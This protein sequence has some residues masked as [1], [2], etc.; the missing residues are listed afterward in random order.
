VVPS[1]FAEVRDAL[2]RLDAADLS[3]V[4]IDNLK[5]DLTILFKG[6]RQRGLRLD[7]GNIFYRGRRMSPLDVIDDYTHL[8]SPPP[9]KTPIGRC[10]RENIPVF[11][12]ASRRN[13]VFFELGLRPGDHV[14][15]SRWRTTGDLMFN[16]VGYTHAAFATLGSMR[17]PPPVGDDGHDDHVEKNRLIQRWLAEQFTRPTRSHYKL[18]IAITEKMLRSPPFAGLMYPTVP[19]KANGDNFAI[20]PSVANAALDCMWVRRYVV[21]AVSELDFDALELDFASGIRRDVSIAWTGRRGQWDVN[22][23]ARV[24]QDDGEVYE[25]G[26]LVEP[27]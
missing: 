19:M 12:C 18:T 5:D 7:S 2:S 1:T 22:G 17:Q 10:N 3:N 4:E 6:Y 14:L 24:E 13:V 11:Y 20:L 27:Y 15:L 25:D 9:D 26:V 21:N 16:Q 23:N 8:T